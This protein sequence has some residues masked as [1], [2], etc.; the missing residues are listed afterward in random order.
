MESLAA[1]Y[2]EGRGELESYALRSEGKI[3]YKDEQGFDLKRLRQRPEQLVL[4]IIGL[5]VLDFFEGETGCHI[6]RSLAQ[7]SDVVRV[8]VWS[9]EPEQTPA[10]VIEDHIQRCERFQHAL[11]QGASELPPNP[12]GLLPLVREYQFDPPLR[13]NVTTPLEIADYKLGY[14]CTQRVGTLA[15]GLPRLWLLRMGTEI[16]SEEPEQDAVGGYREGRFDEEQEG[17]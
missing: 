17:D 4:K 6:W 14:A 5:D 15:E 3:E 8:R 13:N 2:L 11:E 7:G 9:A 12:E 16:S 10:Q 1:A